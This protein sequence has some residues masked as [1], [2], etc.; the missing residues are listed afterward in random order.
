MRAPLSLIYTVFAVLVAAASLAAGTAMA[1]EV[2]KEKQTALG[3]YVTA[4][5]AF[6]LVQADRA[7]VLFVDVR[8]SAELMFVGMTQEVDAHVPFAEM[9]P[10]WDEKAG[11]YQM[12]PNGSF[13]AQIEEHLKKKGLSKADKVVLM[14]RSGERS[15]RGVNT[16]AA[17]GFTNAYSQTEGFEGDMGK[18]G[19]RSLNG[20]KN[21]GLPWGYKL[22]KAKPQVAAAP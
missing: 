22:D 5:E 6:D 11:R 15:A 14:C 10:V 16:L 20:W 18:D 21:A 12:N 9:S 17:A 4:K 1:Q 2:P 8:T 19:R 13:V 7:K 3:K